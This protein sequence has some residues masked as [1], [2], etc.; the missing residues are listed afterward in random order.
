VLL[1]K[2]ERKTHPTE[3]VIRLGRPGDKRVENPAVDYIVAKHVYR[4]VPNEYSICNIS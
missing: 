2:R 4:L 3:W 1:E